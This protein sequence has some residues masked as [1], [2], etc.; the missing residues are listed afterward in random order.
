MKI[1]I[2]IATFLAFKI[3]NPSFPTL[4]MSLLM[5]PLLALSTSPKIPILASEAWLKP[6]NTQS[7]SDK[8]LKL[9]ITPSLKLFIGPLKKPFHFQSTLVTTS[10]SNTPLTSDHQL[11]TTMYTS[12]SDQLLWKA[13]NSKED[14]SSLPIQLFPLVAESPKIP[15]GP[16]TQSSLL[17]IWNQFQTEFHSNKSQL[18][19]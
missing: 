8:I 10:T 5:P 19:G 3:C 17:R 1:T 11:L 6:S 15:F 14:V 18:S 16:E 7:E 13:H 2:D 4:P 12:A 9:A